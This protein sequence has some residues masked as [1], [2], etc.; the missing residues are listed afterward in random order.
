MTVED[1]RNIY[2]V[3]SS[4]TGKKVLGVSR[5]RLTGM[6]VGTVLASILTVALLKLTPLG[7][8]VNSVFDSIRNEPSLE[9]SVRELHEDTKG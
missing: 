1:D 6:L 7:E 2:A 8:M 4:M 5:S 3:P 9:E